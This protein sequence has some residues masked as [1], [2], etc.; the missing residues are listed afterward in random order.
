MP[1]AEGSVRAGDRIDSADPAVWR[2]RFAGI[3]GRGSPSDEFIQAARHSRA[4]LLREQSDRL[5][6]ASRP[7]QGWENGDSALES[8]AVVRVREGQLVMKLHGRKHMV[9]GSGMTTSCICEKYPRGSLGIRV[10]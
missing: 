6:Q 3:F 7:P 2:S 8:P 4:F 10:P 5:P 1:P 9:G